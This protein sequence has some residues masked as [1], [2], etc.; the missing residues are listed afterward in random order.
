MKNTHLARMFFRPK[1]NYCLL[2]LTS[3][4][5]LFSSRFHFFLALSVSSFLFLFLLSYSS[6]VLKVFSFVFFPG[7]PEGVSG[8]RIL[9]QQNSPTLS[10]S[11]DCPCF[12]SPT[13]TKSAESNGRYQQ[14]NLHPNGQQESSDPQ[15]TTNKISSY[16]P[17]QIDCSSPGNDRGSKQSFHM[18]IYELGT[19]KML[20]SFSSSSLFP[21]SSTFSS[22]NSPSSS[23]IGNGQSK[24]MEKRL[25]TTLTNPKDPSFTIS[26]LSRIISQPNNSGNTFLLVIYSINS[27]GSSDRNE[28]LHLTVMN[29]IQHFKSLIPDHLKGKFTLHFLLVP[30]FLFVVHYFLFF[31]TFTFLL[32][33]AKFFFQNCEFCSPCFE[34]DSKCRRR[35]LGMSG[36]CDS[37]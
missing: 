8:C 22:R 26:N 17:I 19:S 31:I 29:T 21:S 35:K 28:S 37:T 9:D 20:S 36:S 24:Y 25:L 11:P 23:S 32:N 18:D 12:K 5:I 2:L 34:M 16:L 4:I 30:Y 6:F 10:T 14:T 27:K 3:S 7:Q 1:L 33:F 15:L 13:A